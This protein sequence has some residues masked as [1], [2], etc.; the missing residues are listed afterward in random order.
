MGCQSHFKTCIIIQRLE[1]GAKSHFQFGEALG[2]VVRMGHH[3]HSDDNAKY[4][5]GHLEVETS[6]HNNQLDTLF[7]ALQCTV[8]KSVINNQQDLNGMIGQKL[9]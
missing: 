3:S 5:V 8:S 1:M 2:R 9:H 6:I 4:N 7:Q